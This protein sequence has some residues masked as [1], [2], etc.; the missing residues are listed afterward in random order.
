[1]YPQER[2]LEDGHR[3]AANGDSTTDTGPVLKN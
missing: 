1:M 2:S 3:D